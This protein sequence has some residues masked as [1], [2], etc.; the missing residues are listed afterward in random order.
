[1]RIVAA[2]IVFCLTAF[3]ASAAKLA[4]VLGNADYAELRDLQNTHN[5]A[6]AYAGVFETLGYDV[7][8]HE[9]LT[10]DATE[11][12]FEAFL[13]RLGPGDEVIFVYSGHGWSD[14]G[15]NYLVPVDAPSRGRDRQLKRASLALKNG[16]NG[17]LDEFEAAGVALTVA[18]I[19]AC[20]DNPFAAAPGTKS[21]AIKR[22]LAPVE[23]AT[24]TFVIYSAGEGQEALDR[25]RSDP[26]EQKLSVF[27]RSFIPQLKRGIT[28]ERAISQA[29]VDTAALAKEFED[30]DQHPAYYDQTLGET[31]LSKTCGLPQDSGTETEIA[32][33]QD[34]CDRLFGRAENIG[35]CFAYRAYARTCPNHDLY[36]LAEGFLSTYCE[37]DEAAF[38]PTEPEDVAIERNTPE[39][40][41]TTDEVSAPV[42]DSIS[43]RVSPKLAWL[44]LISVDGM[45]PPFP[46]NLLVMPDGE[47]LMEMH[48]YV[49]SE[50]R[51]Q[52]AIG[53]V[54][55]KGG[56]GDV[57]IFPGLGSHIVSSIRSGADD[58]IYIASNT[59][60]DYFGD[61]G[62]L[63]VL[64]STLNIVSERLFDRF[65]KAYL[66]DALPLEDGGVLVIGGWGDPRR[67]FV[68]KLDDELKPVF[69]KS[70][71]QKTRP[72]SAEYYDEVMLRP[73]GGFTVFGRAPAVVGREWHW[74]YYQY[75]FNPDGEL[76]ASARFGDKDVA[77]VGGA[78]SLKNGSRILPAK[79]FIIR[80]ETWISRHGGPSHFLKLD[81]NARLLRRVPIVAPPRRAGDTEDPVIQ[82]SNVTPLRDGGFAAAGL[83]LSSEPD[84][85]DS[86]LAAYDADGTERWRVIEDHGNWDEAFFVVE[87]VDGALMVGG[88]YAPGDTR[89]Y[90]GYLARYEWR[91]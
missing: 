23:A 77:F 84:H 32:V 78:V 62:W 56:L 10:L 8:Y 51:T 4:F 55:E 82:I 89:N 24:G 34:P 46:K 2:T 15:T 66:S 5:D 35:Q 3:P 17:V 58:R 21:A 61:K 80:T 36:P 45:G 67:P 9:D 52:T 44:N 49:P 12:A 39:E 1:M 88:R 68:A 83:V 65:E 86:F 27:S 76:I 31:C 29:Q 47:K 87:D 57:R 64:D 50:D 38:A 41:G 6:E 85:Y 90:Q 26:P 13:E 40:A 19:D 53:R 72:E 22:G 74:R 79:V 20:R 25:L 48:G 28:L 70:V 14:G 42:R 60:K 54:D 11:A 73:D 59:G 30:H 37:G 43:R 16:F 63:L 71:I 7:T 75:A 81:E 18:I 33:D 91:D 69:E